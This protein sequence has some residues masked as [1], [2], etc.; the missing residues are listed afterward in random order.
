MLLKLSHCNR[1]S[2]ACKAEIFTM[3]FFTEV[4]FWS[5]EDLGKW[6]GNVKNADS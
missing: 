3:W 5:G 2:M 1:E 6:E 4:V